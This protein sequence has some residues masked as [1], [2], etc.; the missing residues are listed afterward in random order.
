MATETVAQGARS[1]LL[2]KKQTALGTQA[3]GNFTKARFNTHGLKAQIE[4]A[5]SEEIRSDR[6]VYDFRHAHR[7]AMG[8]SVHELVYGDH[9]GFVESAMFS[10]FSAAV[11]D[12]DGLIQIGVAPQY[13]SLED[14]AVDIVQYRMFVDMLVSRAQFQFRTGREAIV[15]MSL[16]WVGTGGGTPAGSSSGGTAVAPS[17]NSPFD[18]FTGTMFDNAQES[19]DELLIISS[20]DINID[21]GANP[22]FALT[23][24]TG[25]GLEY[26]RGRI[27][28][29]LTAFY[30][31]AA[32]LNRHLNET[33]WT[34]VM[35][36]VDPDGNTMEF[37]LPRIKSTDG[38]V[39]VANERS[40]LITMSFQA[41]K[42]DTYGSALRITK[43]T[44]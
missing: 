7:H 29:Q 25:I 32:L 24:Q 2:F 4:S 36:L 19:G 35:D 8:P 34:L 20:L 14:G 42:D 38:D 40:R 37:R 44:V 13:F 10:T 39:P 23:Q 28:G 16:D 11:T 17:T 15:R 26:G 30:K 9:D 31:D 3:T 43:I 27:T 21:N 5:E 33:E 12:D 6:E 22:I 41:L 18:T 1:Q